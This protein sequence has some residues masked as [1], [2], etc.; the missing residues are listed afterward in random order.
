MLYFIAVY[1]RRHRV[2][3]PGHAFAEAR[4]FRPRLVR[5]V[6]DVYACVL[7]PALQDHILAGLNLLQLVPVETPSLV[8]KWSELCACNSDV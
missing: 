5:K 2:D 7:E 1:V 8:C 6:V 4:L 3:L